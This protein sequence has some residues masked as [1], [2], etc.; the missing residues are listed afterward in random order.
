MCPSSRAGWPYRGRHDG[1]IA[2]LRDASGCPPGHR[3]DDTRGRV[4]AAPAVLP[5][6]RGYGGLTTGAI[7]DAVGIKAPTLY[8]YF[9][10]GGASLRTIAEDLQRSSMRS[11]RWT[12]TRPE[13]EHWLLSCGATSSSSS[14]GRR[15]GNSILLDVSGGRGQARSHGP[16]SDTSSISSASCSTAPAQ[17]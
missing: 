4:L 11:C 17:F 12:T 15:E 3:P 2:P 1:R 6:A 7:A 8:W 13:G 14:T 5:R 10:E 9:I 16:H